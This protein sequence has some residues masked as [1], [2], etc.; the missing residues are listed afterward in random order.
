MYIIMGRGNCEASML[1]ND[2]QIVKAIMLSHD[3]QIVKAIRQSLIC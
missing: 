1:S 3:L 2:L